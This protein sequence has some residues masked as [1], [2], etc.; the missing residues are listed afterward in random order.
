MSH[1]RLPLITLTTD[2]GADSPY[3]AQMKGVIYS[4][5]AD[6]RIVDVTHSIVPQSV[7]EAAFLLPTNVLLFPPGAVHVVVVDPGVGTERNIL[8]VRSGKQYLIGPDNGLFSMFFDKP[9][10][11]VRRLEDRSFWRSEV[12]DTFHGRDIMAPVAAALAADANQFEKIGSA[13]PLEQVVRIEFPPVV[14]EGNGIQGQ[15]VYVDSFG[16]LISNLSRQQVES[17]LAKSD[18]CVRLEKHV[19]RRITRTYGDAADGSVVAL[20]GSSEYLEI[21]VVGGNAATALSAGVGT[22]VR[23]E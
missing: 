15:I 9:D 11:D 3:V 5:L 1:V 20:F 22:A 8:C 12:S 14:I 10:C 6:C 17:V 2:F 21:A 23:L 4:R 7:R 13:V 19:I 16:N 18:L